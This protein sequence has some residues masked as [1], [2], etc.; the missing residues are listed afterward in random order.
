[1]LFN[2]IDAAEYKHVI[3]ETKK[4]KAHLTTFK[5]ISRKKFTYSARNANFKS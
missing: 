4:R 1:M 3:M 5:K 2:N